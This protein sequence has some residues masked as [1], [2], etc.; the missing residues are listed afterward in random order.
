MTDGAR[1]QYSAIMCN[2]SRVAAAETASLTEDSRHKDERVRSGASEIH[3]T[4]A[5]TGLHCL[6]PWG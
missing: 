4:R 1:G 5:I 2:D 3:W 6:P